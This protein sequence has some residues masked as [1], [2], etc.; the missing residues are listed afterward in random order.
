MKKSAKVT[1][2][3]LS[4]IAAAFINGCGDDGDWVEAK[5]CVDNNN[6]VVEDRQCE[7]PT[8]SPSGHRTGYHSYYY[9]GRGYYPGEVVSGGGRVPQGG[10]SYRSTSSVPRGG[11][12]PT[13]KAFVSHGGSVSA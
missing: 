5:R 12:G 13:G 7:E 4:S 10:V 9:G 11:F 1:V 3:Y 8:T 2:V 6:I